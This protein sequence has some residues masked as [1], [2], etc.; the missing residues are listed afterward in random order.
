MRNVEASPVVSNCTFI[1]NRADDGG[2]MLNYKSAP[3][4]YNCI[5]QDNAADNGAGI[6]NISSSPVVI[7][8]TFIGNSG[9]YGS[10][11]YIHGK[12]SSLP[13]V[14]N[15]MFIGN[16]ADSGGGLLIHDSRAI[17]VNSAFI[18]NS[19]YRGGG[20]F[21]SSDS[22]EVTN[23]TFSANVGFDYGSGIY[24][25]SDSLVVT[26]S[27]FWDNSQGSLGGV[28]HSHDSAL[29]RITY[30]LVEDG[31]T[32]ANG[33]T[34][35]DTGNLVANPLFIDPAGDDFRLKRGSPCINAGTNTALPADTMD[36]NANGNTSETIP[37]DLDGNPRRVGVV[38]MGAYERQ[39][40][41]CKR[42]IQWKCSPGWRKPSCP[43]YRH[44]Q[45]WGTHS[46]P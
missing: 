45:A 18:G 37:L 14:V 36:L 22:V 6:V 40:P 33:C 15:S 17:V 43:W 7:H 38:D 21:A 13:V 8:S 42:R 34:T 32:V 29:P 19:A 16:S 31:C 35:E 1:D 26:N 44:W 11:M 23:C 10:G 3:V 46:A 5:F 2:G 39:P 24:N 28:I 12:G 27:I 25:S 41:M 4:I 30:S 20:M 9:T